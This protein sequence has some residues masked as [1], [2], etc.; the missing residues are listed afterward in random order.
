[1]PRNLKRPV[2]FIGY[3]SHVEQEIGDYIRDMSLATFFAQT[4]EQAIKIL[5]D[6]PIEH[7]V[8]NLRSMTDAIILRYINRSYPK[9]HV[10]VSANKEF[11]EII[12]F[13]NQQNYAL[14]P[15]PLKL[16]EL[17]GVI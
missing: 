6:H 4:Q 10:V 2:L 3:D 5:D 9:I 16:E 7:V 17:K 1:M 8:L 12:S 14:L 11:E 13:F 15:Q